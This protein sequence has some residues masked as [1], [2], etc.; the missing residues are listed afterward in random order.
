VA[1][2]KE[3][4]VSTLP[5]YLEAIAELAGD[6]ATQTLWY[7][8]SR[9]ADYEL[10]PGLYR[11]SKSTIDLLRDE[12]EM[13]AQFRARSEPLSGADMTS[14]WAALFV[15]QHYGV[16]TRLLDWSENAFLALYFAVSLP[17]PKKD[18]EDAAVWVLDPAAWN[19]KSFPGMK[20][21]G[22]ALHA[23]H[24]SLE[25]YGPGR[26]LDNMATES[27]AIFGRY[28]NPRI[29]A[30]RGV[31]TVFGRDKVPLEK[32]LDERGYPETSLVRLRLPKSNLATLSEQVRILGFRESMVYPDLVGL[33]KE[34][35]AERN[36]S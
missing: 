29:A 20:S 8:G 1:S 2:V 32:M 18:N 13:L 35:A 11:S 12:D 24:E 5:E 3:I 19:S 36:L 14:S 34:I 25:P 23:D 16:P 33:A 22:R 10:V 6:S 31:F 15:M 28:N 27:A 30:Q 7:R 4:I 21:P 17:D 9:G 26:P